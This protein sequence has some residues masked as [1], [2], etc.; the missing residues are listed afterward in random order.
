MA[1]G[2]KKQVNL[3]LEE[4][5]E[6]VDNEILECKEQLKDLKEKRKELNE[7]MEGIQKEKLYRA[8][9]VIVQNNLWL[10]ENSSFFTKNLDMV[11]LS[12]KEHF[13]CLYNRGETQG[14]RLITI[15]KSSIAKSRYFK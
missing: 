3:T 15:F 1:R 14:C 11:I 2:R 8:V 10:L 13:Y 4:Q 7:Q 5:L 6:A 12:E 9:V